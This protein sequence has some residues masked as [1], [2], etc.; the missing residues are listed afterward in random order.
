MRVVIAEDAGVLREGLARLLTDRGH[1]ISA[2]VADA[3]ALRAAVAEYLPDV[4][5]A[6]IR[7]PPTHTDDGLRSVAIR[8]DFP[9]MG[10]FPILG[11]RR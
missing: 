10:V 4:V 6:D 9:S 8:R 3:E 7:M 2:A 5:I 11:W 1:E